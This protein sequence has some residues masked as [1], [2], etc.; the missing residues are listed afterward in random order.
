MNT[1]TSVFADYGRY[2]GLLYRDKDYIG[3]VNYI[4]SLLSLYGV[5]KGE[6]LEFGCG[7]GKHGRLLADLGYSIYG[8]ERSAEMVDQAF[9]VD[10][11]ECHQGDICT[12]DLNRSFDAVL[13]L[14]H[15]ISY[16]TSNADLLAVFARA[17]EHLKSNGLFIF[18]FWYSPAVYAQKPLPRIKRIND[19]ELEIIRIAEPISHP[20]SNC[21]DVCYT[22]IDRNLVNNQTRTS[23]E[24]HSMRHLSLP[25]IDLL[26]GFNG[27]ERIHAEEFLTS[28]SVGIDTWGVCVVLRKRA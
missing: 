5:T 18:D 13:S 27:F 20:E 2:Y 3:E 15:V 10:G 21:V 12:I 22:V 25:E 8:V 9:A 6:L 24:T 7:T 26:A 17:S 23:M 14:F 11:F 1:S 19:S 4:H 16:Q 28:K